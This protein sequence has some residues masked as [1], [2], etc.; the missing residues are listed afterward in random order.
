MS[1][2]ITLAAMV[3]VVLGQTQLTLDGADVALFFAKLA[4]CQ[5]LLVQFIVVR[6]LAGKINR[7]ELISRTS[8]EV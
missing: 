8:T 1:V 7:D 6:S 3:I 2:L 4:S 5:V